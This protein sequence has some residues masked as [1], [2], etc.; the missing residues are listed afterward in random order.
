LAI[1]EQKL[2]VDGLVTE[3]ISH[4][5]PEIDGRG[6]RNVRASRRERG[7]E[8]ALPEGQLDHAPHDLFQVVLYGVLRLHY[9]DDR[10]P[11]CRKGAQKKARDKERRESECLSQAQFGPPIPLPTLKYNA[12]RK[13]YKFSKYGKICFRKQRNSLGL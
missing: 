5:Q 1:R 8:A 12:L 2:Q 10:R 7:L 9:D 4:D 11:L 6:R 3:G 13:T